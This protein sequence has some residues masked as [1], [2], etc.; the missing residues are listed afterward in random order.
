MPA[1]GRLRVASLQGLA[2][3]AVLV[4]FGE[5]TRFTRKSGCEPL[6]VLV[7]PQSSRG[8]E[9]MARFATGH[10]PGC[11][12]SAKDA[13]RVSTPTAR[14]WKNFFLC[15]DGR[16]QRALGR[17]ARLWRSCSNN[18]RSPLSPCRECRGAICSSLGD[19][20]VVRLTRGT[21]RPVRPREREGL[22]DPAG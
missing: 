13:G 22:G 18:D 20:A 16:G 19:S 3:I 11:W 9:P 21:V 8:V 1:I 7:F 2:Q 10:Q 14:L 4:S 12:S 17:V 15:G 6:Q 5:V